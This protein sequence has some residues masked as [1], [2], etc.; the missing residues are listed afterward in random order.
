MTKILRFFIQDG[1]L[2]SSTITNTSGLP[3]DLLPA[4][5]PTEFSSLG[6]AALFK[7]VAAETEISD[8]KNNHEIAINDL[9]T[10]HTEELSKKNAEWSAK[11]DTAN[12]KVSELSKEIISLKKTIEDGKSIL[13]T[14]QTETD[15]GMAIAG[16]LV[17]KLVETG[18]PNAL[19]LAQ[20]FSQFAEYSSAREEVKKKKELKELRAQKKALEE[21][22]SAL[23]L[24]VGDSK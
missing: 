15:R 11:L 20:V 4:D 24:T 8:L 3:V 16:P 17:E 23:N 9:K 13:L 12:N 1:K 14:H 22:I 19:S 21:K 7:S 18:D 5:L 6:D 10:T 2:L